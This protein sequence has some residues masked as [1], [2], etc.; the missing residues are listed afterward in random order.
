MKKA[1][2]VLLALSLSA[3]SF[4]ADT[5]PIEEVFQRY[6]SAYAKKDFL[7]AAADMLPSDLEEAK[8]ALLPVFLEGQAHKDKEV[9]D[10]VAAFFGRTVGK[11]RETM[12]P[13][14]VFAGMNRLVSTA[15]PELFEALKDA[16]V[17]IIFVRTM[18]ADN[19]EVH[20]QITA[21]GGSDTDME[22]L[23]KKD[24]RWWMRV[25]EQPAEIAAHFKALLTKKG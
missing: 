9:Q 13:Q 4:A 20:F 5:K 19:A 6:W 24:G 17:S 21:R 18:D 7:K 8:R 2:L 10:M 11:S 3:V 14:E 1:L 23:R 22:A 25:N 12:S 16:S 15:S